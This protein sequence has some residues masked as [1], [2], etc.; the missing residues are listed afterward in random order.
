MATDKEQIES[1]VGGASNLLGNSRS[2]VKRPSIKA[3]A[4]R[5]PLV[6]PKR[7]S[8]DDIPGSYKNRIFI[9]GDYKN[10][11]VVILEIAKFVRDNLGRHFVPIVATDF[12]IPDGKERDY[13]LRLLHNCKFA[14][15]EL[16]S[17]AGQLIEVERAKDYGTI[18]LYVYN[19]FNPLSMSHQITAMLK[20]GKQQAKGY[21]SLDEL[22]VLLRHQM[23]R[24]KG[25]RQKDTTKAIAL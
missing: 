24:W 25:L 14:I 19:T 7:A 16:T 11:L 8:V 12:E 2:R 23:Q 4:G 9:G 21:Q 15:F 20:I 22:W 5:V 17:M 18:C 1:D 6:S 3:V 13:C 10:Q